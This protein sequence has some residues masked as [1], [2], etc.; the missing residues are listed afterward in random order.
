[1]ETLTRENNSTTAPQSERF[2]TPSAS[3]SET[4]DG[5]ILELE[6]PGVNKNGLDISI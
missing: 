4:A 1:M 5:Y 6:M 2:I 3:V